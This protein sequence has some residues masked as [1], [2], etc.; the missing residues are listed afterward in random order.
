MHHCFNFSSTLKKISTSFSNLRNTVKVKSTKF[1]FTGPS[2]NKHRVSMTNNLTGNNHKNNNM[3]KN[4][5][6]WLKNLGVLVYIPHFGKVL[7][8]TNLVE[9]VASLS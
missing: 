1:L 6:F 5:L 9:L 4:M 3:N 2:K 7:C 8:D